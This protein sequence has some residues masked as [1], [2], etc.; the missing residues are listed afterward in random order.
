M[1][2]T[3]DHQRMASPFLAPLSLLTAKRLKVSRGF[4]LPQS[5]VTVAIFPSFSLVCLVDFIFAPLFDT[6]RLP[7]S[8]TSEV[9]QPGM[10]SDAS[11]I[12]TDKCVNG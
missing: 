9:P 8:P 12:P 10:L 4:K 7:L 11:V 3:V 5:R 2:G 1:L 6:S